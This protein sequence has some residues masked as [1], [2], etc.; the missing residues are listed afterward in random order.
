MFSVDALT[1]LVVLAYSNPYLI[2]VLQAPSSYPAY[3]LGIYGLV[4]LITAPVGGWVLDRV[5][6]RSCVALV[7]AIEAGGLALIVGTANADGFLAGVGLLSTGI[8]VSWIVLFHAL[9]DARDATSR[10]SATAYMG[11]TSVGGTGAGVGAAAL[12][13]E[14]SH[15]RLAFALAFILASASACLMFWLFARWRPPGAVAAIP[16]AHQALQPPME[17]STKLV[18]G[19]MIFAHFVL[20]TATLAVFGPFVLRTL[21]LSLLHASILLMPA[22]LAGAGAMVVVGRRSKHGKRLREVALLYSVAAVALLAIAGVRSELL[23]AVG[24]IPFAI[25]LGGAQPLLNASLLD[26]SHGG[27]RLRTGSALGWLFFAEGLGSVVGPL[28]VGAVIA[29][30]G[31]REGM[32]AVGL[33]ACA[34]AAGALVGSKTVR[35]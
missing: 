7:L 25:A 22:G 16:M 34:L 19:S 3:A 13:S 29:F 35:L 1:A 30:G 14:T 11:L 28:L 2:D 26:V 8:A 31:V 4:K 24:A 12:I 9:G 21:G 6:M 17:R 15:W 5:G 33:T 23:L 32:V 20:M 18:A 10:G 27:E